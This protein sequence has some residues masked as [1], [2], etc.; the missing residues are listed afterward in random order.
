MWLLGG[1]FKNDVWTSSDGIN[2]TPEASSVDWNA[3][4]EFGSTVH[5]NRIWVMG[6]KNGLP[7][8]NDV[9]FSEAIPGLPA[10]AGPKG[11]KGDTGD[12]GPQ[13]VAGPAGPQGATG[14]TG[15]DGAVLTVQQAQPD[16][17]VLQAQVSIRPY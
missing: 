13:G 16:R 10:I 5:D 9:W 14:A 1:V 15:S 7:E 2:W 3:R 8:F 17:K 11:D 12:T 4:T 6:G